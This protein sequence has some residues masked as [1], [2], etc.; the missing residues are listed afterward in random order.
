MKHQNDNIL[1]A[2]PI[3]YW[4]TFF[5]MSLRLRVHGSSGTVKSRSQ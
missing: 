1:K 3:N 2:A 5:K 4:F